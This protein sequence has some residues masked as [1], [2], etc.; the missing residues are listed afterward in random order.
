VVPLSAPQEMIEGMCCYARTA[1]LKNIGRRRGELCKAM[2]SRIPQNGLSSFT[3]CPKTSVRLMVPGSTWRISAVC[4]ADLGLKHEFSPIKPSA[5]VVWNRSNAWQSVPD[6]GV[7]ESSFPTVGIF[8]DGAR[9]YWQEK[10]K[11]LSRYH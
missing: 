8:T 6:I 1:V 10:A 2:G 3:S 5:A 4:N 9:A 7:S 11:S